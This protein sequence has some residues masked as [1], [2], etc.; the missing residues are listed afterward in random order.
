MDHYTKVE[1][2]LWDVICEDGERRHG[3]GFTTRQAAD[4]FA[5]WGHCCTRNHRFVKRL[6][7]ET[8]ADHR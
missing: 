8:N 2:Y 3:H 4:E 6:Q 7:E 1:E 5:E